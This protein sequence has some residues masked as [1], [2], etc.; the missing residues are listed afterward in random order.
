MKIKVTAIYDERR[1]V[2]ESDNDLENVIEVE[3]VCDIFSSMDYMFQDLMDV[4]DQASIKWKIEFGDIL[5]ASDA[6]FSEDDE[7]W[8]EM[9]RMI[10]YAIIKVVYKE[11]NQI[12]KYNN[13]GMMGIGSVPAMGYQ[14]FGI[15]GMTGYPVSYLGQ[16]CQPYPYTSSLELMANI[17]DP[18]M[19][20]EFKKRKGTQSMIN[21]VAFE[22]DKM[23]KQRKAK[24][25]YAETNGD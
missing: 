2:A 18:D 10:V 4:R 1:F 15:S 24:K 23:R 19:F 20:E 11:V 22:L 8:I 17:L 7:S 16:P 25:S 12:S 6:Q 9:I 5:I 3:S 21:D 13:I 14:N